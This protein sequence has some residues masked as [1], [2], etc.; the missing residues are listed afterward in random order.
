[1][2]LRGKII[3]KFETEVI[4]EKFSKREIVLE[5]SDDGGY[6]QTIPIE[7][8][9]KS[10]EKLDGYPV[11]SDV[12][13]SINIRGRKWHNPKTNKDRYF[14]SISG[15]RIQKGDA[16]GTTYPIQHN[17]P[18]GGGGGAGPAASGDDDIPFA[19]IFDV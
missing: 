6:T 4:S 9:N 18:S 10:I 14:V 15:W 11:G 13:I 8:V 7:F 12:L 5:V 1:M 19:P 17:G 2:E 3:E 16:G